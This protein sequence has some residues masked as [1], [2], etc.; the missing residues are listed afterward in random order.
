MV[1]SCSK[2]AFAA[3]C[4][5]FL[6]ALF[7]MQPSCAS[8]LAT[9]PIHE[10]LFLQGKKLYDGGRPDQAVNVWKNI[11][12]DSFYGPIISILSARAYR[13]LGEEAQTERVLREFLRKHPSSPYAD[14]ARTTLFE[15]VFTQQKAREA[16]ELLPDLLRRADPKEKPALIIKAARLERELKRYPDAVKHYRMLYLEHPAAPEGLKAA[17]ELSWLVMHGT[18]AKPEYSDT[19]QRARA[20][21]LFKHGRFD[22]AAQAYDTLLRKSPSDKKLALKLAESLYKD[23]KNDKALAL[24]KQLIKEGLTG[25]ERLEA[26]YLLSLLYWRLDREADFQ[27]CT[28]ILLE[29]GT[30]KYKKKALFNLA[31][32]DLELGRLTKAEERFTELLKAHPND[33]T[34]ALARWKIAW[35]QYRKKKYADAARHFRQ[36]AASPGGGLSIPARY[37]EARS[38]ILNG[39]PQQATSLLR[40]LANQAPLDY[41]GRRAT[42]QLGKLKDKPNPDERRA[43]TF[44]RVELSHEQKSHRLVA[45]GQKLMDMGL[46]EFALLNLEALPSSMKSDAAIVYLR[47]RAA[48]GAGRHGYALD[49]LASRFGDQIENPAQDAPK[50]FIE[51]A[52]PRVHFA[53][54]VRTAEKHSVDPNLIWALIRQESRYDPDAVSPA[55]ALGLMQVMP[56]SAGLPQEKGKTSAKTI[57]QLLHPESN[58]AAGI[59]I[60]SGNLR[61]FNGKLIPAIASYNADIAKVRQWVQRNQRMDQDEFVEN[62]PFLETRLYVKKVLANYAAYEEL[63]RKSDLA[64]R[65]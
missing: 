45:D 22:L 61:S 47:A 40:E 56:R 5:A 50:D 27:N 54:T 14:V 25:N 52:Y 39:Q 37:W 29:T 41:Y 55:G 62:I 18:I 63:Y 12:S 51:M 48:Y 9:S 3:L 28:K 53:H 17:E 13:R 20:G 38:L 42:Q 6:L 10:F 33:S 59:R 31:A 64:A 7:W 58:L 23:R 2:A 26:L 30:P 65:W 21:R 34:A 16:L 57:G 1:A 43:R 32:H 19:D 15:S 46:H 8:S 24:L 60:L 44:P 35:I 4:F 11:P 49:I 36:A